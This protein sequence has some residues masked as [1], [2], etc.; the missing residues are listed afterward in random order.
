MH[1]WKQSGIAQGFAASLI[2]HVMVQIIRDYHE[3][4][5]V[6]TPHY[7]D[8]RT[9]TNRAFGLVGI[10]VFNGLIAFLQTIDRK[11]F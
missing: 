7:D 1:I 9:G 5:D 10:G 6:F 8:P 11:S 2:N 4:L 3:P